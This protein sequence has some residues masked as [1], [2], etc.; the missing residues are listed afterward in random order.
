MHLFFN[1][2]Y[3][4]SNRTSH[5]TIKYENFDIILINETNLRIT[6]QTPKIPFCSSGKC[7]ALRFINMI[8]HP[9]K[10]ISQTKTHGWQVTGEEFKIRLTFKNPD[11]HKFI[12]FR[13]EDLYGQLILHLDGDKTISVMPRTDCSEYIDVQVTGVPGECL[14][15]KMDFSIA[16][17]QFTPRTR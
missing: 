9:F 10:L 5:Q 3:E 17:V 11:L 15:Q 1:L 7:I 4:S 2:F 6:E 8:G 12:T 14:S 13:A 16:K